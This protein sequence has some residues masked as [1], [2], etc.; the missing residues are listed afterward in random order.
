M[1][2]SVADLLRFRLLAHGLEGAGDTTPE[3]VV[4]RMLA[5]QAQDFGAACWALGV[6]APGITQ[7]DVLAA[8]DAGRVVR[9]WPM[10]GTLHFVPPR[11]LNWMLQL[12]TERMVNGLSLR[13]RQLELEGPDFHKARDVV[14]ETIAGGGSIGRTELMAL[15]EANGI[16]TAGQRGYH[17][18]YY[19]AQTGVLCWGPTHKTQQS[20]V[21][22]DEWVADPRRLDDDE[23]LG[24]F[25]LRYVR[26]HGPATVKDFVWWTK[27]T[28]A[29][30]KTGIAV[31]GDRL[32]S[33]LVDGTEYWMPAELAD[34]DAVRVRTPGEKS[35]VHLLPA[36]DEYF[37]GYQNRDATIS[38][39]D[40]EKVVPGANGV[41][42]PVL[43]FHG[44]VIGTWKRSQTTKRV[45]VEARP[46]A[47]L[48]AAQRARIGRG[49]KA[50]GR[51]TG[52]PGELA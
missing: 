15:W 40:F 42:A 21:L 28:V 8:L 41:F 18:I 12:T 2:A 46:F 1:P 19:L 29:G 49:V 7:S 26:G 22:L 52:L 48:S 36:F 24:E 4:D 27:G 51:F 17:L 34:A 32:T 45:T 35:A 44:R 23:A 33:I 30:A 14:T 38:P 43:V 9:S 6:R 25:F 13:H 10:R 39:G 16:V 20:L 31:A 47:T 50:Y 3:G 37:I 5:V 11:D